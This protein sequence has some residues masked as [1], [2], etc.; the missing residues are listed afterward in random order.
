MS[1]EQPQVASKKMENSASALVQPPSS[2]SGP[3]GLRKNMKEVL[4]TTCKIW[5]GMFG[6]DQ[7]LTEYSGLEFE[8]TVIG[9][10]ENDEDKVI[11][12]WDFYDDTAPRRDRII[13][14]IAFLMI[15]LRRIE[16]EDNKTEEN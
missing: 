7:T 1:S 9:L 2:P 13:Q 14:A 10:L 11:L 5:D 15:E 4:D 3:E 16:L 12:G 6:D 8:G